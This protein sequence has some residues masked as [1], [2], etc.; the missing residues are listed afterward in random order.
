MTSEARCPIQIDQ[1]SLP[2][3]PLDRGKASLL[4][5]PAIAQ[6]SANIGTFGDADGSNGPNEPSK[7]SGNLQDLIYHIVDLF[8]HC[9]NLIC[10][11]ALKTYV[12]GS[13]TY[14]GASG[15]F[16]SPA[17]HLSL[18][19]VSMLSSS[20]R[21][22][23]R[24]IAGLDATKSSGFLACSSETRILRSPWPDKSRIPCSSF[25]VK[26][27]PLV[28]GVERQFKAVRDAEF[29]EDIVEVVLDRGLLDK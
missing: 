17:G 19:Q 11:L 7:P 21:V 28:N 4:P 18:S 27:Q 23:V 16:D 24:S 26:M 2:K 5:P 20:T 14:D 3:A 29:L 10:Q 15:T 13:I 12:P 6:N 9:A 22:F 8:G 25:T 1:Y